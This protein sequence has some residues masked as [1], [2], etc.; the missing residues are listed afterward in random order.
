ME[1]LVLLLV[2]LA[3]ASH[4]TWNAFVKAGADKLV[5]LCLVIFTTSLPALAALPFLPIPAAAAWPYLIVSALVHYLYYAFLVTAYR[6]GDLSLTYPIARG[7]APLLVA[8]GAWLLAG[9]GLSVWRWLGVLIVSFGIMSLANP[10]GLTARAGESRAVVFAGLTGLTIAGYSLADGMGVRTAGSELAYI[11]WLFVLSGLPMPL[12]IG[13]CRGRASVPLIK[14]HL[15]I[16]LIGGL[17]SGFAY[18]VVIWAMSA[19]PIAMVVSLRETSVL[20]AAAIGSLFLK[21]PF[22][23]RR[24]AAAAVI[25][26]G[27]ALMNLAP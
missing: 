16:G 3:A 2:L 27:A 6:H 19:A 15:K 5:S 22:G 23:A 26:A 18:S 24:I 4:A 12:V 10:R 7:S 21:E 11:A 17:V 9:E 13:W 20:I 8:L 1:P 25:V 14:A